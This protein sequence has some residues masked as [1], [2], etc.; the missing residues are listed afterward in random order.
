MGLEESAEI[1]SAL[2]GLFRIELKVN[3]ISPMMKGTIE[4]IA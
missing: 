1:G 4:L 3:A 2:N